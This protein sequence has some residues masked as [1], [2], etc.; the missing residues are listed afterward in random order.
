MNSSRAVDLSLLVLVLALI[1]SALFLQRAHEQRTKADETRQLTTLLMLRESVLQGY[2]ESLRSE[3][4]L[5]S[6]Q[7][8]VQEILKRLNTANESSGANT[9][10]DASAIVADGLEQ[11]RG[12]RNASTLEEGIREFAE[13]HD[14]YDV[15]F[16]GPDGDVLFTV[17]READ[18]RTNL[19]DCR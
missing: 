1:I 17:A 3:V 12:A 9:I 7:T 2:L 13:Y 14:Y 19:V 4:T 18:Y 6:G 5:W 8:I 11:T 16:I 15:F 10:A